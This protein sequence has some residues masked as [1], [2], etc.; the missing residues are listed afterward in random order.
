MGR[1]SGQPV[2][3][4]GQ[5][6]LRGRLVALLTYPSIALIRLQNTDLKT[7]YLCCSGSL[8]PR[9]WG[10][11]PKWVIPRRDGRALSRPPSPLF[12]PC[13]GSAQ[14]RAERVFEKY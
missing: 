4:A 12:T 6:T 11:P 8:E 9:A 5:I 13:D 1:Y 10:G 7:G 3:G 14:R 2:G